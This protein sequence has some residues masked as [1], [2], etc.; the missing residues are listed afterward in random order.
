M[1]FYLCYNGLKNEIRSISAS[2]IE[3]ILNYE[4]TYLTSYKYI[5]RLSIN[6]NLSS[7]IFY[8]NL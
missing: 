8:S 2:E 5:F 7:S 3:L 6:N 1:V 4:L